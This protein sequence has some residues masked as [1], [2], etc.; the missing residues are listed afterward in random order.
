MAESLARGQ[1]NRDRM[2]LTFRLND[3]DENDGSKRA[4]SAGA[5]PY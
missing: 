4:G 1:P 2:T 3:D 5:V